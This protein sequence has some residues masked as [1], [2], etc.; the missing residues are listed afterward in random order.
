M[1]DYFHIIV[2]QDDLERL[3]RKLGKIPPSSI[4]H[5]DRTISDDAERSRAHKR[6]DNAEARLSTNLLDLST[7]LLQGVTKEVLHFIEYLI[8]FLTADKVKFL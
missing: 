8:L 1:S 4:K 6:S 7:K 3:K 2:V 5:S